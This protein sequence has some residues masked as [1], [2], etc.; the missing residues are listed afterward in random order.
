MNDQQYLLANA[1]IDGELTDDERVLAESDPDVMSEVELL[2]TLQSRLRKVEPPTASAKEAAFSAAMA[3]FPAAEQRAAPPINAAVQNPVPLRRRP[4]YARWLGVA[5]AV[6]GVGLL[7]T[8]VM[9][10]LRSDDDDSAAFEPASDAETEMFAAEP[11]DEPAN[12]PGALNADRITESA[13]ADSGAAADEGDMQLDVDDGAGAAPATDMAGAGA[14]SDAGAELPAEESA[15]EPA[16][17]TAPESADEPIDDSSELERPKIDPSQPLTGPAELGA[18]GNHLL[19]LEQAAELPPTPNTQCP[20]SGLLGQ[21]QY[22]FDGVLVDV[23]IVIDDQHRTV[24][25]I[26]PNTCET[27]VVGPLF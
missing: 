21:T 1:Y 2:A 8:V 20:Q 5:A 26:D 15:D 3:V 12:E 7:G 17:E 14:D 18:Y 4:A 13:E 11:A 23:F 25:A 6:V 24:S 27:L 16:S 10:G 22:L 19:E 9:T